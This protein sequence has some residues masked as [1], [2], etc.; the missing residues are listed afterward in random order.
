ML[1]LHFESTGGIQ[2][3]PG[4]FHPDESPL[5]R[6]NFSNELPACCLESIFSEQESHIAFRRDAQ[7]NAI[8]IHARLI[9]PVAVDGIAVPN[10]EPIVISRDQSRLLTFG[11]QSYVVT[12]MDCC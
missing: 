6:N 10:D 2:I 8:L 1:G 3:H 9:Q 12:A 11:C 4:L 7:D 5:T